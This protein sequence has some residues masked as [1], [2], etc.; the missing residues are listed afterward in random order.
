MQTAQR[1]G[2]PRANLKFS[3]NCEACAIIEKP[4]F[5]FLTKKVE[6][7]RLKRRIRTKKQGCSHRRADESLSRF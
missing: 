6:C 2:V 7:F 3:R 5:L 4:F 1:G